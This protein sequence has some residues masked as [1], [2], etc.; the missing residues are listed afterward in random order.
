MAPRSFLLILVLM[1]VMLAGDR[2]H[3]FTK[4]EFQQQYGAL[5][6]CLREAV[7]AL[8][9][10]PVEQAIFAGFDVDS[11]DATTWALDV[12][13]SHADRM[14]QLGGA[15]FCRSVVMPQFVAQARE[16]ATQSEVERQASKAPP[17]GHTID[18]G[19]IIID[20]YQNLYGRHIRGHADI[21][22]VSVFERLD[23]PADPD[24]EH[25]VRRANRLEAGVRYLMHAS[26]APDLFRWNTDTYHAQTPDHCPEDTA[27]VRRPR[28]ERIEQGLGDFAETFIRH[29]Q[30]ARRFAGGDRLKSLMHTGVLLHM[31]QDYVYHRGITLIQHSGLSY[32]SGYKNDPDK[33]PGARF[34]APPIPNSEAWY[35]E[36]EAVV[37]SQL[38]IDDALEP[39]FLA[40]ELDIGAAR[41]SEAEYQS[42]AKLAMWGEPAQWRALEQAEAMTGGNL[43][44]YYGMAGCYREG[45]L[46]PD[47]DLI[48]DRIVWPEPVCVTRVL[49]AGSRVGAVDRAALV[50]DIMACGA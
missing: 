49:I 16:Q 38:V 20:G 15:A 47:I 26:Q 44:D 17:G 9:R 24:G 34:N 18:T 35:R 10:D 5:Q 21:T 11:F 43:I 36:R 41:V 23:I 22:L 19:N 42:E 30:A 4:A 3:G 1:G 29:L 27:K 13:A 14:M 6:D 32:L 39:D 25:N 40:S 2:S 37:V 33:P 12:A 45:H 46:N 31:M 50:R 8:A 48:R 7:A 28:A